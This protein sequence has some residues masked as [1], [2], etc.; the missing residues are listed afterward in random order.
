ML[1]IPFTETSEALRER[2]A[3]DLFTGFAPAAAPAPPRAVSRLLVAGR[4]FDAA[5]MLLGERF[6]LRAFT[7]AEIIATNPLTVAVRGGGLA[8]L[9]RHGVA[10]LFGVPGTA[11]AD[12]LEMLRPLTG[13][14]HERAETEE[15]EI[16]VDPA[17]PEG[18]QGDTLHLE[19]LTVERIQIV[20]DVLGKSVVLAMYESRVGQSFDRIEP[21]A[22]ELERR[23][24]IAATAPQL[25]KRIGTMLLSEQMM[26]GP[27]EICEKPETLWDY[28]ALEGLFLRF[29]DEF[30][31]R[32]R[33]AV[34][35]RKLKFISKTTRTLLEL[36]NNRHTLRVEWYIV[37]LI[38]FE[39][40]LTL[41]SMLAG[42]H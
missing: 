12:F 20:A 19:S 23:G 35:E 8:V 11:Q 2:A 14:R 40:V 37:L 22:H 38:V 15:V 4:A 9:F 13:G 21:L 26:V 29:E 6:D 36:L 32:E 34:L 27:A 10:V 41:Y 33:H 28:P 39:I 25:L 42:V 5:A 17:S 16:R 7:G 3:P 31:I 18:I 24:R 30:E 1:T